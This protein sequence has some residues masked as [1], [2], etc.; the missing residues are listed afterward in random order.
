MARNRYKGPTFVSDGGTTYFAILPPEPHLLNAYRM[1]LEAEKLARRE[2]PG[3]EGRARAL[4]IDVVLKQVQTAVGRAAV[5]TSQEAEKLIKQEVRA[6]QV[7]PDPPGKGM[8]RRLEAN[9][10]CR[11]LRTSL[12]GG[13]VGIG[14]ISE[15][16][17]VA[18]SRG[19]PYWRAQEFGSQ[20]LVNWYK[21]NT[22]Y[23]F[24]QPGNSRPGEAPFRTHPLFE[25]NTGGGKLK[26]KKAIPER[27]FLRQGTATAEVFRQ[28]QLGRAVSPAIAEL[29]LIQTGNHPRLR[30]AR[31]HIRGRKPR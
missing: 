12:P 20:H 25:L 23:G 22:R 21:N 18:D 5:L 7:R 4:A 6:T 27:A 13:G 1:L 17:K 28:K 26:V 8:G 10:V 24:F 19:R 3:A 2:F 14:D 15:L 11:P 30:A 31:Q 9:I 16:D 29:R